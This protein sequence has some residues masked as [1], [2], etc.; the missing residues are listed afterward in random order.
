MA[1]SIINLK[2]GLYPHRLYSMSKN[3][4]SSY[5]TIGEKRKE[6]G[7]CDLR[8]AL[9]NGVTSKSGQNGRNGITQGKRHEP[10]CSVRK[11]TEGGE[12]GKALI[13]V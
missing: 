6:S 13:V 3:Q 9:K 12:D 1:V 10:R 4:T 7:L 8:Q 11:D 5:D 2:H